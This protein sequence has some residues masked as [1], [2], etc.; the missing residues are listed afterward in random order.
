MY[1]E[2]KL[3]RSSRCTGRFLAVALDLKASL[4]VTEERR[5][6]IAKAY[7]NTEEEQQQQHDLG[8]RKEMKKGKLSE[9]CEEDQEVKKKGMKCKWR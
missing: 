3:G 4:H 2:R 7:H 1:V 5:S 6:L 9:Y 8:C